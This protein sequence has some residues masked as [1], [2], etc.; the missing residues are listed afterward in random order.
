MR[1]P[2]DAVFVGIAA[3]AGGLEAASALVKHL[4]RSA[5]AVYIMAQHMSP[6]HKSLL[7]SLISRET[8]LPV[9]ELVAGPGI[10][11]Q[12]DTIYIT[13]PNSDVTYRDGTLG[14][15]DP[16]GHPAT[17]KPSA[18]RLFQSLAAEVTDHSVGIVLSGTGSDGSYGVQAIREAGGITIAQDAATAKYDGMPSSAIE[19]GC[20][21]LTLTPEQ[22]GQHLERILATP[23]DFNALRHLNDKPNP[24]SEL[25]QILHARTRVD[26][27]DYK[28][29]TLNRRISRRMVALTIDDY[30]DYVA[31]CRS[32]VDEVDALFRDLLI[33]VT[34]FF[35][36]APQFEQLKIQIE[37]L[38]RRHNTGQ[39]RVWVGGCATGEE[40]YSISI[41][42]AEAMGGLDHL[43]KGRLQV[44]ATDIDER[45]LDIARRGVYPI[46]AAHDIPGAY[47]DRYFTVNGTKL[48]VAPELR[49]VTLFSKHNIFHD[50]P[51]INVDLMTLRNV[52]IYFNAALQERVLARAHYALAPGGML[53]LG[54][55]E[56]V[57]ALNVHF[58]VM[59]GADKIYGKRGTGRAAPI[60]MPTL[61]STGGPAPGAARPTAAP[62]PDTRMFDA[63][64]K[65]VAPNG[66]IATRNSDIVR[67]LGDISS[68]LELTEDTALSLNT[69]ILRGGL[70]MEASSLISIAL[71]NR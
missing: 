18:D 13:P 40:A 29:N 51:F 1:A 37:R 45:A 6:T 44:F 28:E 54:T 23:R 21:D 50:P 12:V 58:E 41:L 62:G 60:S 69:R 38:V 15:R 32:N 49:A 10:V 9:Q 24:L 19:T 36:D 68:M 66:F 33:S 56:T 5:N 20:I 35:R 11:P 52:L 2:D 57:G 7:T 63:L 65:S 31:Y 14:L 34:R 67:V 39:I 17:P 53:F 8:A 16:E 25:L 55:S 70:G 30:H 22:I 48:E 26:F 43:D 59:D 3:S 42:I 61:A 27:H 64:A 46:T 47:L 71:K 4:P